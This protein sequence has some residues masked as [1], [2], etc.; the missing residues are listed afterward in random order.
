MLRNTSCSFQFPNLLHMELSCLSALAMAII[1]EPMYLN[2]FIQCHSL[3][4]T[5]RY[6]HKIFGSF[7]KEFVS[8][9][10]LFPP[11]ISFFSSFS[12][13]PLLIHPMLFTSS[14]PNL[15]TWL[16]YSLFK[17]HWYIKAKK[18]SLIPYSG[19]SESIKGLTPEDLHWNT[20]IAS[21]PVYLHN[22]YMFI[23]VRD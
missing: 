3:S 2:N 11:S 5:L 7:P 19:I 4:K 12:L 10:I 17:T 18:P 1:T 22:D 9:Y 21:L 15:L 8:L 14:F 23:E 13:I 6:N 16:T 20:T